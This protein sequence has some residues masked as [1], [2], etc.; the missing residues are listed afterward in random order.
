M[1]ILI[2]LIISFTKFCHLVESFWV[3]KELIWDN[4]SFFFLF[5]FPPSNRKVRSGQKFWS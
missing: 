3:C 2:V 5:G 1:L 4:A